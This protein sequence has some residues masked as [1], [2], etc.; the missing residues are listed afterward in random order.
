M[1]GDYSRAALELTLGKR[2]DAVCFV[3]DYMTFQFGD[4]A[5]A[6]LA[7]PIVIELGKSATPDRPGYRDSLCRQIGR[8][9]V[10]VFETTE[11]LE[12]VFDS[13][14]KVIIA[15]NAPFPPGPE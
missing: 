9:V 11:K 10:S 2:L 5:L 7:N 14:A 15:L 4:L 6:A 13:D 1:S 3:L 8:V 12:I